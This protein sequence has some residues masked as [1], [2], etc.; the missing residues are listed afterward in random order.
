MDYKV[1]TT[2]DKRQHKMP[3]LTLRKKRALWML[4]VFVL[5]FVLVFMISLL[6][7][8]GASAPSLMPTTADGMAQREVLQDEERLKEKSLAALEDRV[9]REYRHSGSGDTDA[10][11]DEL[12]EGSGIVED[13][14]LI[15]QVVKGKNSDLSTANRQSLIFDLDRII[16]A[17]K[18]K[19]T[20]DKAAGHKSRSRSHKPASFKRK[21]PKPDSTENGLVV[22]STGSIS[23][24]KTAQSTN[25]ALIYNHQYEPVTVFE[26][27]FIDGV[28]LNK[29]VAGVDNSVVLVSVCKD[30]FDRSGRYVVFPAG[31]R[32][33]GSTHQVGSQAASRLFISFQRMILPNGVS[34][35]FPDNHKALALDREGTTGVSSKVNRHV[36]MK[37]RS[38]LL[39]GLLDGIGSVV[40]S[41]LKLSPWQMLLNEISRSY[42]GVNK[43]ILNRDQDILP[44]ITIKAGTEIKIY[45]ANDIKIS[46]YKLIEERSYAQ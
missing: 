3:A 40:Q 45:I 22:Y 7:K 4:A 36:F 19:D 1:K 41:R 9:L 13:E 42:S 46:P 29:V 2:D 20:A 6:G 43:N 14:N 24:A 25:N 28:L 34:V 10:L 38:S 21:K 39:V 33:I 30:Y 44:T 16:K 17:D 32:I 18:G 23:T 35:T 11:I 31:T 27:E 37:Y 15:H 12:L 8:P 5:V 26:G